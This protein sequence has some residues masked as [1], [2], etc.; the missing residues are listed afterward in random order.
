MLPDRV[1]FRVPSASKVGQLHEVQYFRISNKWVCDCWPYLKK[2]TCKHIVIA[3]ETAK[4]IK[5]NTP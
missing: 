2:G 3:Q 5:K 4:K 1:K